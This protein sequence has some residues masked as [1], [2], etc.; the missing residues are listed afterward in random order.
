MMT[1]YNLHPVGGLNT[2]N[3][4]SIPV[5]ATYQLIFFLDQI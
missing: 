1:L 3:F 5:Y 4:N 2:H